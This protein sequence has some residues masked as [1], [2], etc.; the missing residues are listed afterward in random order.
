MENSRELGECHVERLTRRP[1]DDDD[2]VDGVAV[3]LAG[4]VDEHGREPPL[5]ARLDAH[6]EVHVGDARTAGQ[7]VPQGAHRVPPELDRGPGV[8]LL[9]VAPV[10]GCPD[11]LDQPP[12]RQLAP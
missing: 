5:A 1:G 4:H 3:A 11:V 2:D 6:D 10:L 8:R 9:V 7:L 12:R